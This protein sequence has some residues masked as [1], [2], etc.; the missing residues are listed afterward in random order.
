MTVALMALLALIGVPLFA[1]MLAAAL[2]TVVG[3][4]FEPAVILVDLFRLASMPTLA[5][6]PLFTFAGL[7]LSEGR[8]P[9]R[10]LAVADAMFG[11]LPGGI[12]TMV[13]L[14]SSLFT[15]FTGASGIAIVALGGLLL[16][17]L[18]QAG[19]S[20]RHAIGAITASGTIG[21]LLPPSLPIILYAITAGVAVD[22]LFAA[23][24]LPGLL[25]IATFATLAIALGP[26]RA[27]TRRA[28][29]PVSIATA[30]RGV[31]FE[32]PLPFAV[33]YLVIGGIVTVT[34]AA[35]IAAWY[36]LVLQLFV[37][38]EVGFRDL[39]RLITETAVLIGAILLLVGSALAVTNLIV[40]AG[41]PNRLVDAVSASVSSRA[42]FLIATNLL[43]LVAGM[44]TD[45]FSAIVILVPILLPVATAFG[46][47][48]LHFGVIFLANLEI[49]YITPPVGINLFI[50]R[51]RFG[52]GLLEVYRAA[53]PWALAL[54]AAVLIITFVP[55][56]SLAI[57]EWLGRR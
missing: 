46:V 52:T 30:L 50:S 41:I 12:G 47:D 19:Y 3:A 22:A 18:S 15:A 32:L 7:L 39:I 45:V 55:W 8:T 24:L 25:L 1:V 38:R 11:R 17:A 14:G 42:L 51:Y 9:A 10:I 5:A 2:V 54:L 36:A 26:R 31:A 53:L 29:K 49:G 21:Q 37:R 57:P 23:G 6:L 43:L 16:P 34:E 27:G 20:R 40:D 48:P 44:L 35:T 13:V 28:R 4:G 56:V 33:L